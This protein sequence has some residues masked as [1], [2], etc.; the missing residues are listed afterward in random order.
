MIF[1]KKLLHFNVLFCGAEWRT[2][3]ADPRITNALLY[4]LSQ[5][6]KANSKRTVPFVKSDAKVLL[7]F[8]LTTTFREIFCKFARKMKKTPREGDKNVAK[9]KKGMRKSWS[10]LLTCLLLIVGVAGVNYLWACGNGVDKLPSEVNGTVAVVSSA[11]RNAAY[12]EQEAAEADWAEEERRREE[13][14]SEGLSQVPYENLEQPAPLVHGEEMLLFKSQFIISYNIQNLCPNYVCWSLTPDRAKGRVHRSNNFHGDPAM[15][16]SSRVETFDYNGSGYDR[17][18]MCPAGDNKNTEKAM[19]ESF[20]MTNMCPQSHD[21]N[22]GAWN[23]LEMQCRSWARN[24]GTLYICCGPIFDDK[25]PKKVGSRRSMRIAVPDRFFKV[26]LTLGRV[27]KAIGFIYP[28][29]ACSG[30]MR[31]YAV[32]VDKVERETG[33]DFFYQLDDKQEKQLEKECNPAAWGI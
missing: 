25:E 17:G 6:G 30:D 14:P 15:G 28:N 24:Y 31:D 9:M 26:I 20:C 27:P 1:G 29:R 16:E 7:F 10:V 8:V 21:L 22:M 23:D 12:A 2:R 19:D 4:Q 11:E 18:H 13:V 33:M 5:F 32:S 3:T